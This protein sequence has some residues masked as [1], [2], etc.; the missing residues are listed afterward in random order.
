MGNLKYN[1]N[2][3]MYET[4]TDL[5]R[6]NCGCQEMVREDGLGVWGQQMKAIT[7]RI[8][9]VL[10]P[11]TGSYIQHPEITIM[12]KNIKKNTVYI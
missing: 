1:T 7:Y 9:K 12:E 3:P 4:E 6:T 5:Q 8:D 11:S 10:L 2:E